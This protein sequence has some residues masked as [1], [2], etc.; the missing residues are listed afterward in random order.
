MPD[1]LIS[2][3]VPI[4]YSEKTLNR[5]VDSIL[6]QTYRNFELLLINDG[7]TDCSGEICNEYARKDNPIIVFHKENAGV[8][9]A[10]NVG[11][12]YSRGEWVTFVDSDDLAENDILESRYRTAI[13]FSPSLVT[14][15]FI[16]ITNSG[17]W[18]C[19]SFD[20]T[21]KQVS[22]LIILARRNC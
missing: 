13:M 2:I 16:K 3:I 11:L 19:N 20:W 17:I 4:Y 14:C 12:D 6:G 5:C 18:Y 9:S 7:S 15:D 21:K 10:R 1:S 22:M 8:S